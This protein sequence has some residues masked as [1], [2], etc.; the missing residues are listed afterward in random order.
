EAIRHVGEIE[1]E[2]LLELYRTA[3]IYVSV[4]SSDGTAVSVLEAMMAGVPVVAT[5]APG[6]D[7]AILR[8]EQ[9]ALLVPS[10]DAESLAAAILRLGTDRERRQQITATACAVAHRLGNFEAELDRAVSLYEQL[11][12]ARVGR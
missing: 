12:A 8:D 11:V 4:P 6:I 5:D 10:R 1:R 3:D 7:P 9:T 2:E